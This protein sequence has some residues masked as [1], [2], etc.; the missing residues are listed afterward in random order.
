L[1]LILFSVFV[2][3]FAIYTICHGSLVPH[4]ALMCTPIREATLNQ[5]DEPN[6]VAKRVQ[7]LF[8]KEGCPILIKTG[9]R[10]GEKCGGKVLF[11]AEDVWCRCSK[12]DSHQDEAYADPFGA[13]VWKAINSISEEELAEMHRREE[14]QSE[15]R[16]ELETEKARVQVQANALK[17]AKRSAD[18]EAK[19]MGLDANEHHVRPDGIAPTGQTWSYRLGM[20]AEPGRLT[21]RL[22]PE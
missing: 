8:D 7:D 22:K 5:W 13:M 6:E 12:V 1:A 19:A 4:T 10:K 9:P 20:W 21:K 18:L 17:R 14:Q 11:Y 15:P 16:Q 3:I 2:F